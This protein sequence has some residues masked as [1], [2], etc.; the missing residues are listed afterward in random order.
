MDCASDKIV[1]FEFVLGWQSVKT[2]QEE[3]KPMVIWTQNG[4]RFGLVS[5]ASIRTKAYFQDRKWLFQ[6][7]G[8]DF[9]PC[10]WQLRVFECIEKRTER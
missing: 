4:R 8:S 9:A 6:K 2:H 10:P 3:K 7:R 1:S 5:N